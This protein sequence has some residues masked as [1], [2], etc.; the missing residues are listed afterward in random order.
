MNIIKKIYL[1]R[2][3]K[4]LALSERLQANSESNGFT[5]IEILIAVLILSTV[6]ASAVLIE[7]QIIRS[8]TVNK[9]RFQAT[10]LAQEGL[11]LT[12]SIRDTN[13][14]TDA[15]VWENM[16]GDSP[17]DKSYKL[18]K[19]GDR[20]ILVQSAPDTETTETFTLNGI[21]YTRKIYIEVP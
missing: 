8:G 3:R 17:S 21:E 1:E 5:L 13:L 7:R 15:N 2:S 20:W 19:S 16:G 11:N 18:E 4:G 9:H 14:A 10:G 6:V 12:R